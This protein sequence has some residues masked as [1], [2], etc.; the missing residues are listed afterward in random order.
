MLLNFYTHESR[1]PFD[2][3]VQYIALY[4]C[5]CLLFVRVFFFWRNFHF[6]TA[7]RIYCF[8]A[9]HINCQFYHLCDRE[10]WSRDIQ[11]GKFSCDNMSTVHGWIMYCTT[12]VDH[13]IH[14]M[15]KVDSQQKIVYISK[16]VFQLQ[17]PKQSTQNPQDS[18]SK[19]I[20]PAV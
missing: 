2:L 14:H 11:P 1:Y 3:M 17:P 9:T 19:N 13:I 18:R 12:E 15:G 8:P 16:D 6:S 5:W 10:C 20:N 7:Q 4:I